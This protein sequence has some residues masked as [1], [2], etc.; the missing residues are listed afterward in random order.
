MMLKKDSGD[1]MGSG[2]Q[3]QISYVQSKN[4]L[5]YSSNS[6]LPLF[7]VFVMWCN[8]GHTFSCCALTHPQC[9]GVEVIKFYFKLYTYIHNIC[10]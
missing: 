6:S 2:N 9:L 5:Y 10:I 3:T 7:D 4:S 8:V 1:N